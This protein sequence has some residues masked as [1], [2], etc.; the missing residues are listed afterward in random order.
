MWLRRGALAVLLWSAGL[1][2]AARAE[3]R[4]EEPTADAGE[5]RGG[6]RLAHRFTFVNRGTGPVEVVGVRP[7]CGCLTPRL[8]QRRFAPGESGILVLEAN[9]LTQPEGPNAWRVQV[10]YHGPGDREPRDLTLVLR[11]RVVAEIGVRPASLVLQTDA[12]IGHEVTLTDRRPRPLEVTGARTT[13]PHL[14]AAVGPPRRVEDGGWERTVRVEVLEGYPGGRH[15][16]T[17]QIFTADPDY[18][19][20]RVPVTVVRKPRHAVRASPEAI[21]LEAEGSRPLPSRLVLLRGSGAA[22]VVEKVEADDPAVRC[23]WAAG[24]GQDATLRVEVDRARVGPGG[25]HAA[26][27]V[28]L[29]GPRPETVT[30]PVTCTLK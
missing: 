11:A 15:E 9:T 3:L 19:E 26:V 22:V 12:P 7:S 16:E 23:R 1:A 10:L 14:R 25:L 4:C 13:S 2:G 21:T 30:V 29:G 27:R 6:T 18:P 24:P 28:R 8:G 17:L 20:L 5:V